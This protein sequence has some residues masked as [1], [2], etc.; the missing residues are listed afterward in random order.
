MPDAYGCRTP[1]EYDSRRQ[2]LAS[3]VKHKDG[4]SFINWLLN[5]GASAI[6]QKGDYQGKIVASMPTGR[7]YLL[8]AMV[9]DLELFIYGEWIDG[10]KYAK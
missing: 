3:C 7:A 1:K 9:D 4:V 10:S 5:L 8:A 2:F 6:R